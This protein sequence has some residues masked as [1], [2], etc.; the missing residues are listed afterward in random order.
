MHFIHY[1][2]AVV[3]NLNYILATPEKILKYHCPAILN[4]MKILEW[5]KSRH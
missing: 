4:N 5:S 2:R 1:F 3:L